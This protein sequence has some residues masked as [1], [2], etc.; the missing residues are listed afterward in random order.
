VKTWFDCGGEIEEYDKD[1]YKRFLTKIG[2]Y[3]PTKFAKEINHYKFMYKTNNGQNAPDAGLPNLFYESGI[4]SNAV[5]IL[6]SLAQKFIGE[7]SS[8]KQTSTLPKKNSTPKSSSPKVASKP[9]VTQE[10]ESIT[11]NQG[12]MIVI[13]IAFLLLS[14][15]TANPAPIIIMILGFWAGQKEK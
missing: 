10:S 12:C 1:A 7:P 11:N 5:G 15:A 6:S 14:I 9:V 3:D 8:L 4:S 2:W 13:L